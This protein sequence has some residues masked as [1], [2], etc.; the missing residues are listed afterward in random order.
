MTTRKQIRL[1]E[2]ENEAADYVD[3]ASPLEDT[4]QQPQIVE[5]VNGRLQIVDGFHRTAGQVRFCRD[6]GIDT[7]DRVITVVECDDED[8]ISAA[9]EPGDQQ[10]S[11]IDAIYASAE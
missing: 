8:L 9:A 4:Y 10:Q 2:I 11:A 5:R 1:S 7:A 6:N 3:E